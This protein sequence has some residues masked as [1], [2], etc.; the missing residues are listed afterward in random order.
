[1]LYVFII[2]IKRII[3]M[4]SLSFTGLLW[5]GSS[6]PQM[7]SRGSRCTLA[8]CA[9]SLGPWWLS[10]HRLFSPHGR[11][12]LALQ[13]NFLTPRQWSFMENGLSTPP[14][15]PFRGYITVGLLSDD[16]TAYLRPCKC[17][18][19]SLYSAHLCFRCV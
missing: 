13:I 3:T 1:M 8:H 16:G 15:S 6:T 2:Q 19:I 14:I 9:S 7:F 4:K 10:S 11:G 18:T 12:A 5:C 17:A